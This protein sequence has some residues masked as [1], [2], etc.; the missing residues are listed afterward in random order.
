MGHVY[1]ELELMDGSE[2]AEVARGRMDP[3]EMKK[4]RIRA[5][6]DTGCYQMAI[7]ENI[8]EYLQLAVLKVKRVET[9]DG[10][11][12]MCD[13]VGPLEI[14]YQDRGC[15]VDAYVLPGDSE[16]LLGV[17]PMEAMDVIVH[18]LREELVGAHEGGSL[19]R[20]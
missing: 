12:I 2:V 4:I 1:A 3:Y 15:M 19:H 14:R 13:V 5:L 7:N 11:V 17:I 8:Q 18:P 20:L 9:A 10:R 16:P 6:V